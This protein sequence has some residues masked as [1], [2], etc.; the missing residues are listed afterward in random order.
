MRLPP[1]VLGVFLFLSPASPIQAQEQARL[2]ADSI[3][4][5]GGGNTLIA[6]GNVEVFYQG[7]H[8]KAQRIRYDNETGA[9]SIEG[10]LMLTEGKATT[11]LASSAELSADLRNGVLTSARIVL[12]QQLRID[13]DE[14]ERTNG[15]Y[16]RLDGVAASSCRICADNPIPLWEIRA[17][18]VVH[19]QRERQLHFDNARL[20][21]M[22]VPVFYIPHLR[23]PDP[24]LKRTTGFLTPRVRSTSRLGTGVKLPYFITLGDHRDLTLTPYVSGSTATLEYRYRQAFGSGDIEVEGAVSDDD[25]RANA[26]R[27]HLFADGRFDLRNDY[28]LGFD[29]EYASDDSYLLDYGYSGKDRLD[30]SVTLTRTRRDLYFEAGLIHYKSLRASED[31]N[32]IP[33]FVGSFTRHVRFAPAWLGG[34]ADMVIDTLAAY[35]DSDLRGDRGRDIVRA[36]TALDWRRDWIFANGMKAAALSQ[37][38]L[39]YY[40]NRQGFADEENGAFTT[41]TIG[42]ELRWPMAR[43]GPDGS[44]QVFEPV[45]Q[46]LWTSE[47][48]PAIANEDSALLEFDEGN[49]FAFSRFSGSDRI[50][51]GLRANLGATWTRFDRSGGAL[52]LTLGRIIRSGDPGQF[53][54]GSGL[55]GATS[56]WLASAQFNLPD[57]L[58][59]AGRALFNDRLEFT[60]SESRIAWRRAGLSL[61]TTYIWLENAPAEN[62]RKVSEWTFD[63]SLVLGKG[64]RGEF[65]LRHDF[66]AGRTARASIGLIYATECIEVDLS[67][68]RRFTGSTNLHPTTDFGLSVSLTGFGG[69]QGNRNHAGRCR[70]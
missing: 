66:I 24:T 43:T 45:A 54:A 52:S 16:T 21:V 47:E 56:D 67:L 70:G 44:H 6:E 33:S 60:R 53:T 62:R 15:R 26:V 40:A 37:A 28:R 69:R 18:R 3:L 59:I 48:E 63:S 27:N 30:S 58:S 35:R 50:E 10:P 5:A 19:D 34:N 23:L 13:A 65:G 39:D 38:R 42:A 4:L 25:I 32:E 68:S 20:R 29:V 7:V 8:L 61:A 55:A 12:D 14:I 49:L 51:R 57:N 31:N 46:I 11:L 2:I 36:R 22:G 9:M 41:G 1:L 17:S 64:W